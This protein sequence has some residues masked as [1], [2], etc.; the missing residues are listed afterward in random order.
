MNLFLNYNF[1]ICIIIHQLS[2]IK[3]RAKEL[4]FIRPKLNKNRPI[5]KLKE[6]DNIKVALCTMGKKEN[7]YAKEFI[8]YYVNLG[9]D[10][11]FIFDDNDPN[12]ERMSDVVENKYKKYVTI[13]ENIKGKIKGQSVAFTTCYQ[14]NIDKFDWFLMVDMD[15]FLY[16]V[17]DTLKDFLVNK[18]FKDCDFIKFHWLISTD[19]DLVHYDSRPLFERFKGPFIKDKYIKTIIRGNISDLKYWVHSPEYSPLKNISCNNVGEKIN[20][21]KVN[22]ECV[23]TINI[24]KAFIFHFR[25]KSAEE[26]ISKF[27]R[28]YSNWF[29]N[30]F[31]SF[32][33]GNVEDFLD[34][35]VTDAIITVPAYFN[36]SQRQATK[37]HLKLQD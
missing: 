14:N 29:G 24:E 3:K 22:I 8:E 31:K 17:N 36:E 9:I 30:R 16:I 35:K 15:E 6:A 5:N 11:L 4:V 7:L 2:V 13:H 34:Y 12:T 20:Y 27:K 26:L 37:M 19:N 23:H 33:S 21:G 25:F 28:G 10:Q 18:K 1:F 32:I